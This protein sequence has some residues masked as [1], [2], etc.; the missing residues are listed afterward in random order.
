MTEKDLLEALYQGMKDLKSDMQDMK[1]DIQG[2]KTEM[3]DM[4]DDIQG[5]KTEMQDMHQKVTSIEL[6][7]ENETNRNIQLLA[8]N[9]IDLVNKLN[10]AI[11]VQ[12]KSLLYEVQVSGLKMKIENLERE[13]AALKEKIA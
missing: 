2:I 12:D 11:H 6:N 9:H 10:Q 5:I 13:V 4:K 1:D 7:L 3:Q 8:E